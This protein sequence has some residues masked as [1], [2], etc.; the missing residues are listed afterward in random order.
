MD[1]PTGDRWRTIL[2]TYEF[3][4]FLRSSVCRRSGITDTACIANEWLEF[5]DLTGQRRDGRPL[6]DCCTVLLSIHDSSLF[7]RF[8][9]FLLQALLSLSSR[10]CA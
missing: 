4:T 1:R 5:S 9:W 3:G 6:W 7:L 2:H 8:D 10:D